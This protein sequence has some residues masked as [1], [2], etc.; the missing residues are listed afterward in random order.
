MKITKKEIFTINVFNV[1][2]EEDVTPMYCAVPY[3]DIDETIEMAER[4]AESLTDDDDLIEVRVMAGEYENENGEIWGEPE[5]IYTASNSSKEHTME[6][7]KEQ[8]YCSLE[9]DYYAK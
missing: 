8:G 4:Q 2:K 9:V 5:V 7:R 6:I 1:D 3:Y